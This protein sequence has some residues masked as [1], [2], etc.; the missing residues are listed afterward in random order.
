MQTPGRARRRGFTLIE[1]LVVIAIIAVLIGLLLPAVQS[2]REAARRIQC[3]NNLKQ[4]ALAAMNY[5]SANQCYP[6]GCTAMWVVDQNAIGVRG[7]SATVPR[8]SHSY[9]IAMLQYIE[10]GSLYNALNSSL[11]VNTCANSTIHGVGSSFLWCPS[12]PKVTQ[13]L[14]LAPYGDFS[15]WCYNWPNIYM[16]YTSYAG[17]YGTWYVSPPTAT[18]VTDPNIGA[19]VGNINGM[20]GKY[21]TTTIGSVTDGTSN[22]ILLGEWAYGKQNSLDL[23]CNHW[24]TSANF[25]DTM[26]YAQYPIN[27]KFA[28]GDD[29]NIFPLCAS[30]FHPGGANFAFS[31]GSVHFLKDTIASW[32]LPTG[33]NPP[34]I[35]ANGPG[36]TYSFV[37]NAQGQFPPL[38]VY[39]ALAT[40]AGGEVVSADQY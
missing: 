23:A 22:T 16:R 35:V 8:S 9:I 32:T 36:G 4:L 29:G 1:L 31:D 25:G 5:E 30:S 26:F 27:P 18:G 15:G 2:A 28:N 37:A 38:P 10:G 24:W 34:N 40:R 39:Q 21:L 6:P 7:V 14:N 20:I 12:D 33:S 19:I 17:C 11:H 13:T 3:V